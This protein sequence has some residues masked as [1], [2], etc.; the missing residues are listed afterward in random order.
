[1]NGRRALD[2][3]CPFNVKGTDMSFVRKNR[4]KTLALPL[5]AAAV[6]LMP[7]MTLADA[8]SDAALNQEIKY[9]DALSTQG[10][11]DFTEEVIKAAKKKWPEAKGVLETATVRAELAAGKQDAV[12][13]KINAR[14]D[15]DSLDTWLQ[16]LELAA[17]YFQYSKF[18]EADKLYK[19]FFEKFTK[20]PDAVKQAYVNAAYYYIAMLDKIDRG[21]DTLKIYKLA[22]EQ[23]PN[24]NMQKDLRAQYLRAL[25]TQAEK[26]TGKDRDDKIKQAEDIANKMV[27]VQDSFFGDA[28]N[29]LAYTKM[30]KGDVKGAQE[31]INDYIELLMQ[32]HQSYLE[33][34]PNGAKGY[35][36]LS[37]LPQCRYLIGKMLYDQAKA[38]IAKG[39]SANDD[40]IK[41]LLLGERDPATK[42]RNGQGAFQHLINVYTNYP[43]SQSASL[44]GDFAEEIQK[45]IKSRYNADLKVNA[46]PEQKAKVRQQQYVQANVA[47]DSGDWDNAVAAFTKTISQYGL[48]KEALP[49][50]RKMIEA[51]IRSGN[52]G[53]Q[54]DPY[55]KLQA[56]TLTAALAEGFSGVKELDRAAG[57]QLRKVADLYGEMGLNSMKDATY[58]LFFKY[59]PKHPA[60]VSMQKTIAD[61]KAKAGDAEGAEK[62]YI[63]IR[64]AATSDDQRDA[65]TAALAALVDLYDPNGAAANIAKELA[66]AK[67]FAAHFDGIERP[68]VN[69]AAAQFKLADAYRHVG[70]DLR[71]Q[72]KDTANDKKIAASYAQATKIYDALSKELAKADSKYVSAS[73]ERDTAK[74]LLEGALYQ[75]GVCMQRLPT[76]GDPKKEKA[77]KAKAEGYF[78][79][80]LKAYPKGLYA[81]RAMLQIG[82]LQAAAGK[83]EDSRATLAKLAKDF[84]ESDEAKNSIPMLAD[85]LFKMGMKSEATNTYKQMFAAGGTYTAAQYQTAAEKLLDAGEAKL[86][87]EAADCIL[88]GNNKAY[89][90]KA[91]LLRT[92]GLLADKQPEAAYKQISELLEA[93]GN[94]T[95]AVDAN[96]ALLEVIGAQILN[97]AT[98]EERNELIGKAKKAVTFLSAQAARNAG[99]N[100]AAADAETV[101][102]NLAVADVARKAYEAEKKAN[103]DRVITAIGSALN[104]YRTAMFA[105]STPVTEPIVA[106]N[107][108]KAYKGYI[109]LTRERADMST[110]A[111][112]KLDFLRDVVDLGGEYLEKF[113]NGNYKTDIIN[114]VSQAKIE[115]GE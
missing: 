70:E 72:T 66:A 77:F 20:V 39:G 22:M 5:S 38:E 16:K 80:Y 62:L 88:K 104:A 1:M 75:R 29:G 90:P 97:T 27:W 45:I 91:M 23:A 82:T 93:Y 46:S 95:V 85:S 28:I 87:I 108:Q 49:A 94:T 96:H 12:L 113:P 59:Y 32:I 48:N 81:S 40:T 11:V 58:A 52:K 14:P 43:E 7:A 102:L 3:V 54:L 84:P 63:A 99:D 55:S 83:I 98:F 106:P 50:I 107:V 101:R 19:E 110:D 53:G 111:T 79:D 25:L 103:S 24:E 9:I 31:L 74:R 61:E 78:N 100:P 6:L 89:K 76:G 2:E 60:A 56:E 65:R 42:K 35:L 105:G 4:L 44:A 41:N 86:A 114:A 13:A 71:K 112:E 21:A 34:D 64:D 18:N 109:E 47:F 68:G 17:S 67:A 30:L 10:Y 73:T 36:R 69:A 51:T 8:A 15:K 37:P 57:D 115:L 92:K 33:E 26:S